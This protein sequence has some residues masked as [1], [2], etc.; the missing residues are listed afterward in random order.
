MKP[1]PVSKSPEAVINPNFYSIPWYYVDS[2]RNKQGPIDF[3]MLQKLIK[4]KE[5]LKEHYIWCEEWDNWKVLEEVP[6]LCLD[7]ITK[8]P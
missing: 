5:I 7:T 6:S 8:K 3:S 1:D 2:L 4:E